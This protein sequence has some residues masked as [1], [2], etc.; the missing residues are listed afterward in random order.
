MHDSKHK[1][2][3]ILLDRVVHHAVIS[4][5]EP[6][7]GILGPMDRL[8]R[9]AADSTLPGGFGRELLEGLGHAF[10]HVRRQLPERL[11]RRRR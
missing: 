1:D 3:T 11:N 7:E 5:S 8:D 2:H 9:L 4:D 6:M 10:G